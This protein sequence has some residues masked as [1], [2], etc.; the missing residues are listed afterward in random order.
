MVPSP[1]ANANNPSDSAL[2]PFLSLFFEKYRVMAVSSPL[3]KLK[4]AKKN[5]NSFSNIIAN[6][7]TKHKNMTV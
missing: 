1:E 5:E 6:T 7:M 3:I 4:I 2:N